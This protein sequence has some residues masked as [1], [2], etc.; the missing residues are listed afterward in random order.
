MKKLLQIIFLLCFTF[1]GMA[2]NNTNKKEQLIGAWSLD[3]QKSLT[4]MD[5]VP[6]MR[7]NSNTRLKTRI[8]ESYKGRQLVFSANGDFTQ[9]QPDGR[10][11]S[12]IW[13]IVESENT[14]TITSPEGQKFSFQIIKLNNNHLVLKS[15]STTKGKPYF[16]EIYYDKM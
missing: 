1:S 16:K 2:Q 10:E 4:K 8:E 15:I 9:I 3:Y 5:S 11:N 6:K 14:L 12:G 13:T 7:F